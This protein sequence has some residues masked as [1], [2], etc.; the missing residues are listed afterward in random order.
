MTQDEY[1]NCFFQLSQKVLL[2][3][4]FWLREA[5]SVRESNPSLVAQFRE[6]AEQYA[7]LAENID[8]FW[9]NP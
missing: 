8:K 4:G 7:E 2:K 1:D 9:H 6:R 3:A 5:I